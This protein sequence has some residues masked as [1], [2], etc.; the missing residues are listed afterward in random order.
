MLARIKPPTRRFYVVA[1]DT[2]APV[3]NI[4][5]TTTPP[6]RLIRRRLGR[7]SVKT[8]GF[9]RRRIT[10][11]VD[12]ATSAHGRASTS[13]AERTTTYLWSRHPLASAAW[14]VAHDI[15]TLAALARCLCCCRSSRTQRR[16]RVRARARP[17]AYSSSPETRQPVFEVIQPI[18]LE[19]ACVGYGAS[20]RD[21]FLDL[22]ATHSRA[23]ADV[24]TCSASWPS[25]RRPVYRAFWAETS[26]RNGALL[27]RSCPSWKR[28][29]A[30]PARISL[31]HTGN[32]RSTP[33]M[34]LRVS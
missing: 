20:P 23:K 33:F 14:V 17:A 34:P 8:T 21:L 25:G 18:E 15:P 2:V 22:E 5:W 6:T 1:P 28:G 29:T 24:S 10:R 19:K 30:I 12:P 26:R 7:R 16:S 4:G 32:Q 11:A 31:R 3:L 27:T 13:S 9:L